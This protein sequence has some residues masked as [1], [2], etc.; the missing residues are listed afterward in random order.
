MGSFKRFRDA[1]ICVALLAIPF[2]FLN[3]NLKD[4]EHTNALDRTVRMD[5]HGAA[6]AVVQRQID[7]LDSRVE[8]ERSRTTVL[9]PFRLQQIDAAL[10]HVD[11]QMTHIHEFVH[12]LARVLLPGDYEAPVSRN[13][14]QAVRAMADLARQQ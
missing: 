13:D 12:S 10:T 4:P 6:T 2:F 8:L 3:A 5:F 11:R 1:A 7:R 14:L 9:S